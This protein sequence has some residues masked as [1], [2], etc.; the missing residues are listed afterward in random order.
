MLFVFSSSSSLGALINESDGDFIQHAQLFC[1]VCSHTIPS[2]SGAG[3]LTLDHLVAVTPLASLH[4]ILINVL[5]D[6]FFLLRVS[7]FKCP[8]T[9]SI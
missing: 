5:T 1:L 9:L 3:S 7:W 8:S 2:W 4:L 6:V